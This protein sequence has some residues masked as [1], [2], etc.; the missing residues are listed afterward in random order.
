MVILSGSSWSV[1]LP[2]FAEEKKRKRASQ[3]G[4]KA[5]QYKGKKKNEEA[6]GVLVLKPF[7]SFH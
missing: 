5:L 7:L 3:E 1:H 2:S 4:E 6:N